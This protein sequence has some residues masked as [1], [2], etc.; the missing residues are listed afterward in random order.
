MA[1][2]AGRQAQLVAANIRALIAGDA[3]LARYEPSQPV[4]MV[5]VGP[6]GGSGQLPGS[7]DLA[8]PERVAQA[9]GRDMMVDRFAQLL[10]VTVPAGGERTGDR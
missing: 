5:P 8:T 2:I 3:D 10:G 6:D 7:D 4:I 9:K 1:G